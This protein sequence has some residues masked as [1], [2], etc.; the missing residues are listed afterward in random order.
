MNRDMK[1]ILKL[2]FADFWPGFNKEDNYFHRL[3]SR[4]YELQI[5]EQPD[6]LIFSVF[7]KQHRSYKCTRVLYSG[8]N[9]GV[10]FSAC[11]YAFTGDYS[12][13]P[14]HFRM[15][16]YV[17]CFAPERFVKPE[18]DYEAVLAAKQKFCCMVVSN[19]GGKVR[20]RFFELLSQVRQVDSGGKYKNNIGFRVPDK[21]AFLKEYKFNLAFENRSWPGYT[22]EKIVE[23]MF[24]H[25]IPVYWGNPLI[26]Q[27]FNS[28]AFLNY[29][30]Y[31][32]AQALIKQ[33]LEVDRNP[34]L[35]LQYLKEPWCCGNKL[36][37]QFQPEYLLEIF[38]RIIENPI[39]PVG[40][41]KKSFGYYLLRSKFRLGKMVRRGYL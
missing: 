23:P 7:G 4:S 36:P 9:R 31:R 39:N 16:F 29:H 37:E 35:H 34:K 30:Q 13:H 18:L 19:P 6:L 8:E 25:T 1:E 24:V 26:H 41:R 28:K 20:N 14:R 38:K 17:Y 5:S 11:D 2:D 21:E 40:S 10:D 33:M 22:T 3:L 27:D 12:A 15:P 32:S